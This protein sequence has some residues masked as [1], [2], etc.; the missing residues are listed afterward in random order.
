MQSRIVLGLMQ[1]RPVSNENVLVGTVRLQTRLINIQVSLCFIRFVCVF[2]HLICAYIVCVHVP[3]IVLY[4]L[5]RASRMP[6]FCVWSSH[7]T[8]TH[9][10]A[11]TTYVL[12]SPFINHIVDTQKKKSETRAGTHTQAQVCAVWKQLTWLWS[13]KWDALI[14]L[15]SR[16]SDCHAVSIMA[17]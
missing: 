13:C 6:S 8:H 1:L 9:T 16:R 5:Y 12:I 3:H 15:P 2:V 10:H 11:S 14:S 4:F 17:K 7:A